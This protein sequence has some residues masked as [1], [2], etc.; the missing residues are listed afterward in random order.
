MSASEAIL[1]AFEVC[2]ECVG[3]PVKGVKERSDVDVFLK[4]L[5]W[6]QLENSLKESKN[7]S[8]ETSKLAQPSGDGD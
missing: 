5:L 7:R 6:L 2:S 8:R 3:E 1:Q 4:G